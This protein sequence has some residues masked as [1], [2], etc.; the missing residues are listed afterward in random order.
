MILMNFRM[1][2]PIP[3]NKRK[4]M[5]QIMNPVGYRLEHHSIQYMLLLTNDAGGNP[6]SSAHDTPWASTR[7]PD[8]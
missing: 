3:I 6:T 1:F 2:Q 7:T 5:Q 4:N 8:T